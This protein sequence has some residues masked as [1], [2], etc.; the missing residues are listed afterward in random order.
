VE[1]LH[2]PL[3]A[4]FLRTVPIFGGLE[5]AELERLWSYT[6]VHAHAAGVVILREGDLAKEMFVLLEG[7]VEIFSGAGETEQVLRTLGKGDCFGE[8]ALIDIQPRS[9]SVRTVTPVRLMV[10]GFDDLIRVYQ[11]NMQTYTIIVLNIAREISRRLRRANEQL[12]R[13]GHHD[14]SGP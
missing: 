2:P 8:M 10:I 1:T 3:D 12:A 7:S 14:P 9:A 11:F 13:V 6:E 4:A 5:D